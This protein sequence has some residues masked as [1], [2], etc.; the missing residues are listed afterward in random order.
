MLRRKFMYR[1]SALA[2]MSLLAACAVSTVNGVTTVTLNLNTVASYQ[3]ATSNAVNM[4][5]GNSIIAAAVG[6]ATSAIIKS[7]VNSASGAVAML[8]AAD[9]GSVSLTLTTAST[10]AAWAAFQSDESTIFNNLQTVVKSLGSQVPADL[11]TVFDALQT[12]YMLALAI[13]STAVGAPK[14]P[15]PGSVA[16][17]VLGV[18]AN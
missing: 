13:G 15:M 17:T 5:L 16:L 6:S 10:K 9:N 4:L 12:V 8:Q 2:G 11:Q 7:A 18:P 1:T 14:T 3:Q